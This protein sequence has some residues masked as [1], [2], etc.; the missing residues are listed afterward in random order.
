MNFS[1][2]GQ[3]IL[4][5]MWQTGIQFF[6]ACFAKGN[7]SIFI[8]QQKLSY[9]PFRNMAKN[10]LINSIDYEVSKPKKH[11]II[12]LCLEKSLYKICLI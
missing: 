8:P 5:A 4:N 12:F 2:S 7:N 1:F 11:N 3:K 10:E 6:I 9:F